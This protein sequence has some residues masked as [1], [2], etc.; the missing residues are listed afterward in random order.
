MKYKYLPLLTALYVSTLL[1]SNTIALK[2]IT[3]WGFSIPVGILCFPIAYIVNDVLAEVYG[4]AVAKKVVIYGFI[5][6][7]LMV[8][9]YHFARIIPPD[10]AFQH[11]EEFNIIFQQTPRIALASLLAYLVG[12]LLNSFSLEKIKA[13]TGEKLLWVRTIGSTIIGEGI[14]S[15][16]F[17][18]VAFYG[19]LPFNVIL[20]II[21]TGFFLKTLYE[22]LATPLTYQVINY[23]KQREGVNE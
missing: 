7:F 8:V 22:I 1:I 11:N 3:I 14:D 4:F 23:V 9:I 18:M 13:L 16:I 15:V 2:I 19:I 17:G 12:S 21:G 20:S 10:P 5:G 6:L